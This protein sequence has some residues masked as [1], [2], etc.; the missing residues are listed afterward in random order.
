MMIVT[1][2]MGKNMGKNS[3]PSKN[4]CIPRFLNSDAKLFHMSLRP[5]NGMGYASGSGIFCS[6]PKS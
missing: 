2:N 5:M 4:T 3:M 1:T 6:I